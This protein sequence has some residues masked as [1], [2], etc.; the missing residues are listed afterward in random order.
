MSPQRIS[1]LAAAPVARTTYAEA[2]AQQGIG[3]MTT[4]VPEI[5]NMDDMGLFAKPYADSQP[6]RNRLLMAQ[7]IQQNTQSAA[8]QAAA[9]AMA[10][11]RKMQVEDSNA[12]SFEQQFLNMKLTNVMDEN[13]MGSSIMRLDNRMRQ[14]PASFVQNIAD[15]RTMFAGPRTMF[16]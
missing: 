15:G 14:D 1:P 7:N 12:Q 3:G 8:P 5:A 11:M 16:G 13:Q 10:D 9:G 2:S 4:G 6:E